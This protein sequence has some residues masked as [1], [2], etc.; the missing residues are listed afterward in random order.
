VLLAGELTPDRLAD[1]RVAWQMA[2]VDDPS[3]PVVGTAR[4]ALG[5][6][7]FSWDLRRIGLGVAWSLDLTACLVSAGAAIGALLRELTAVLRHSGMI[8]VTIERF[9]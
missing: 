2:P 5:E 7:L 9:A 4:L 8:P 3:A 1:L 6:D